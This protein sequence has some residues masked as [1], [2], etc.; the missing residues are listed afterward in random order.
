ML[1]K[2][3]LAVLAAAMVA[4]PARAADIL[5]YADEDGSIRTAQV[6]SV[7]KDE[8]KE[9]SATVFVAGRKR[10]LKIPSRRVVLLRRG[11]A[12]AE[13]QWS[14]LLSRGKQLMAI[15]KLATEGTIPGA[16]ETFV[17]IAYTTEKGVHGEEKSTKVAAWHN[18][19]AVFYLIETRYR[20]GRAGDEAKLRAALENVEEFKKRSQGRYE[21]KMDWAVPS[22]EGSRPGKV[23]GWG[24]SRLLPQ[25]LLYEAR[26][27]AALKDKAKA[28]TAYDEAIR[29]IKKGDLSPHLLT[30]G[31]IEK[32]ELEAEGQ[33]S[34]EQEALFRSAGTTLASLARNQRDGFG[35]AVLGRAA[36]RALL[37]GADLLLES[38]QAKN[39]TF[40]VP[41]RRYRA[42][43]AG[44][45][46]RDPALYIGAVTGIGV[47]LTENGQGEQAYKALLEVLVKGG[48]YPEQTQKSLYHLKRAATM[49]ADEI[50]AAGGKGAFLRSE[51][52]RWWAD[53]KERFPTSKW[54]KLAQ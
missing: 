6:Y 43:K 21:K 7:R 19:Y 25:V 36:N 1:R 50:E 44:E 35:K 53:L 54:A 37:R 48:A 34:D 9:F 4:L 40:D 26:C 28:V 41:L 17:K 32:A 5:T 38:A 22:K 12:D 51:A 52:D 42:L 16:E 20:M 10:T 14:K 27:H 46:T 30:Q 13:S 29:R 8:E 11:D 18:M 3:T 24:S 49:F 33:A 23:F 15:D 45:G 39:V 2:S 31:M 47:C